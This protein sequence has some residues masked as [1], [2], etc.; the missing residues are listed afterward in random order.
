MF[1]MIC[2]DKCIVSHHRCIVGRRTMHV[3]MT[4]N[5]SDTIVSTRHCLMPNAPNTIVRRLHRVEKP[6][7]SSLLS[8]QKSESFD[9]AI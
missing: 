9:S 3:S 5:S 1:L 7:L 8:Y 2:S 6:N 4:N